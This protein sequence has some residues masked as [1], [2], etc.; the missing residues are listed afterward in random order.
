[1]TTTTK[2]LTDATDNLVDVISDAGS[3][4]A[5]LKDASVRQLTDRTDDL[6][7]LIKQRPLLAIGIGIGAG[8]LLAR[9]LHH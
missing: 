6:V 8:Y 2:K 4:L 5:D 3:R 7:S 9:V 1:M